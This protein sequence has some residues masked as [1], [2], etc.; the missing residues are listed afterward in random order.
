[1]L[2]NSL[3]EDQKYNIRKAKFNLPNKKIYTLEFDSNIEI[4][5][6]KYMIQ[7]A[8]HL[9]K[10][11]F[12]IFS[13]GIEYTNF[14]EEIFDMIFPYEY[15][16][17]FT[18]EYD[19]NKENFDD[20]ELLLQIDSP[21][22]NHLHKF[23]L[24]YCYTCNT[25]ICSE[26]FINGIHKNHNIQDKCFYLLPSKNL[27]DKIFEN[28]SS[29]P[30]DDYKITAD[31][32]KFKI[33]ANSILFDRLFSMLKNVQEK[34]NYLISYN[35]KVNI[36]SLENIRSSVRDIK[37]TCTKGLDKLKEELH[38]SDI[39]N[40]QQIF[41]EFDSA[42]KEMGKI[43]NEKFNQN[44]LIFQ[45]LNEKISPLVSELVKKIYSSI[46]KTLDDYL[47]EQLYEDIK[48]KIEQKYIKP[49]DKNEIMAKICAHKKSRKSLINP[50][51]NKKNSLISLEEKIKSAH[52]SI[53]SPNLNNTEMITN[54][55]FVNENHSLQNQRKTMINPTSKQITF[56]NAGNS[57]GQPVS[58]FENNL[59]GNFGKK[60]NN[61]TSYIGQT[62]IV[63][64]IN[65]ISAGSA[66]KMILKNKEINYL[67][68]NYGAQ[69]K[70]NNTNLG[71]FASAQIARQI[72]FPQMIPKVDTS[73]MLSASNNKQFE[74]FNCD[75]SY[76]SSSTV[77]NNLNNNISMN[78]NNL[79]NGA[80]NNNNNFSSSSTTKII[81]NQ[82]NA[83]QILKTIETKTTTI[84]TSTYVPNTILP[85][86]INTNTSNNNSNINKNYIISNV[87]T[88]T[89]TNNMNCLLNNIN[90]NGLHAP[91]T[92][93]SN[94]SLSDFEKIMNKKDIIM[95]DMSE[96]ETEI[97]RPTDVRKFLNKDY[98]LFP[99]P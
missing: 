88:N 79:N 7:K 90:N 65:N 26:C 1:M 86:I 74:K 6:L 15:F 98:I 4:Q 94:S 33:E 71:P 34:C 72:S 8:A 10:N 3:F 61:R 23:L 36:N 16:V 25:S 87:N 92:S 85:N 59:S 12:K 28:W 63:K 58:I 9:R 82:N 60:A 54:P 83:P 35:T 24:Y 96:S 21:C 97:R 52:K 57:N 76:S 95:E 69:N 45:E 80:N 66:S 77:L 49:A 19:D 41:E 42:Y 32:S 39:V 27:V 46:Y 75:V 11:S 37:V 64:N 51:N 14:N 68:S 55:F 17:S 43:Q 53:I 20:A 48:N 99:V 22:P 13:N 78:Y 89:N 67:N 47:N 73:T 91:H 56:C 84:T 2:N 62:E 5:E 31:L 70:I 81:T 29:N 44:L 18:I 50:I 30:Y 40:N 93:A 38:I